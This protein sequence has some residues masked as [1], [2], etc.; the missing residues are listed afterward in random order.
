MDMDVRVALHFGMRAA[1]D[2]HNR[3]IPCVVV[4][5][6]DDILCH[7]PHLLLI[8]AHDPDTAS[9]EH[10]SSEKIALQA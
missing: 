3:T 2:A 1:Q 9:G 6:H 10:N 8:L 5:F 7:R 4:M